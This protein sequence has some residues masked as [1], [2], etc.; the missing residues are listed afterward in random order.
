VT[1]TLHCPCSKRVAFHAEEQHIGR[2][3]RC[4][5]RDCDR[6]VEI[7]RPPTAPRST[8]T[9]EQSRTQ[10][11]RATAASAQASPCPRPAARAPKRPWWQRTLVQATLWGVVVCGGMLVLALLGRDYSA[12]PFLILKES[13]FRGLL[14]TAERDGVTGCVKM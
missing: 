13:A 3:L 9:Q 2:S 12:S 1:F 7:R 11:W 14:G 5:E 8:G 4:R 6:I 10:A